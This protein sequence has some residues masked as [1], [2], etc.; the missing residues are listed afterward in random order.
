MAVR[1]VGIYFPKR[2]TSI[3][4][5]H[6]KEIGG[7]P[8]DDWSYYTDPDLF[9]KSNHQRRVAC[10]EVPYPYGDPG[11]PENNAIDQE[12]ADIYDHV[13]TIVLLSSEIHESTVEFIRRHDL[14]K[15]CW[16][17][18][19][20]LTPPLNNGRTYTFMDWF[21]STVHFYKNV[22]PSTLY[23]LNPYEP[24]PL[25]FDA[26]LGRKKRHR[27]R[28][29]NFIHEQGLADKGI[30][31]Y[32]NN[33][34]IDF[35]KTDSSQWQ[36]EDTG[37]SEYKT[38]QW[39]VEEIKYYGHPMSLS[40]VVPLNIYNQTAYSLVCETNCDNNSVFFT[41]KTVKPILARRLFVMVANRYSLAML[42]DLGFKTFNTIIDESY[43]EI[44]HYPVR[45]YAALEQLKWLCNQPQDKILAQCRDIVDHNFNLMMGRNW[46]REFT[47]T[48][49]HVVFD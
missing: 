18:C 3:F 12:I 37:L 8:S 5:F 26:L 23:Q 21:S 28:S 11:F 42:R 35:Q 6:F 13:D 14:P 9:I 15:M 31:T 17:L 30:V 24:K 22:R 2:S 27:D 43:D 34:N 10:F 45:Q 47:G 7:S 16:F 20:R 1:D 40:Q 33:F 4:R 44:E 25:M 32:M 49:S 48:L 29:Y 39:T 46:Y 36:W 41:E 19:G 38:V